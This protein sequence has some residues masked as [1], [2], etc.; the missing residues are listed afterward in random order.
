MSGRISATELKNKRRE[1][2]RT[3]KDLWMDLNKILFFRQQEDSLSAPPQMC[4]IVKRYG[5]TH[6]N[7]QG[8]Y[9]LRERETHIKII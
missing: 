7:L 5:I 6:Y 4:A 9:I 8:L 3:N 1:E 2:K